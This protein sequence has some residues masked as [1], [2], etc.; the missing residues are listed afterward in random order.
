MGAPVL[1]ASGDHLVA[2]W[3]GRKSHSEE[4][5]PQPQGL[6]RQRKGRASSRWLRVC[7]LV[8]GSAK[9]HKGC[10]PCVYLIL[11]RGL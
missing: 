2:L 11:L 1:Q 6:H 10:W 9:D 5:T 8:R 3:Y 4:M 7:C